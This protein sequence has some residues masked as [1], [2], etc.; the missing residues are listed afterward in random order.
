VGGYNISPADS[1]FIGKAIDRV[2]SSYLGSLG[3]ASLYQP[4][5]PRYVSSLACINSAFW[6]QILLDSGGFDEEFDLC[7][8]T[9]MSYNVFKKGY[10]L[11]FSPEI[12]VWHYRRDSFKR[13]AKQFF[14]YGV[15][16]MRSIFTSTDY[17]NPSIVFLFTVALFVPIISFFFP[18]IS[19]TIILVYFSTILSEGIYLSKVSSQKDFV[20]L[21]PVLLLIEH[22]SFFAGMLYGIGQGKWKPIQNNRS[23]VLM[24]ESSPRYFENPKI[25]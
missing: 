8:D 4:S 1:P 14:S 7:E 21:V 5:K 17:A 6:R 16:R 2:F 11:L 24:T 23:V 12:K 9:N 20:K 18:L 15:G 13:F 22:L 3:S 19:L 10:K 25:R